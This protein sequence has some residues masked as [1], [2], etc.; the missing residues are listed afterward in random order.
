MDHFGLFRSADPLFRGL[1]LC[2]SGL[3]AHVFWNRRRTQNA[4]LHHKASFRSLADPVLAPKSEASFCRET[5]GLLDNS[6][7]LGE[8]GM[9]R[10]APRGWC[11]LLQS[12]YWLGFATTV[13]TTPAVACG[14]GFP[15]L[16]KE[17]SSISEFLGR[18]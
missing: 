16:S 13:P 11:E 6:P 3:P 1:R 5:G 12:R 14:R 8:E 4:H 18:N 9:W 10:V 2:R 7:P 15:S 17:G